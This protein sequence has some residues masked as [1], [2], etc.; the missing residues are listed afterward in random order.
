[1][2]REALCS[3]ELTLGD[4]VDGSLALM[5]LTVTW[6]GLGVLSMACPVLESE[7]V[8]N[9]LVLIQVYI[10]GIRISCPRL[11]CCEKC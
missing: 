1:M 8:Q 4:V 9:G 2:F 3:R 11:G 6:T 7:V 10:P 5:V